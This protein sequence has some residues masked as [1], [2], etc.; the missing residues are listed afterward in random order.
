MVFRHVKTSVGAPSTTSWRC[1]WTPRAAARGADDAGAV[2]RRVGVP[3]AS[4]AARRRR[5]A[6]LL[7]PLRHRHDPQRLQ[8]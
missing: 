7:P 6:R 3:G 4:R 8:V 1:A 5:L 2:R